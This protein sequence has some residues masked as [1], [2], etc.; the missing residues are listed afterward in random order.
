MQALYSRNFDPAALARWPP[1]APHPQEPPA[2]AE[3]FLEVA[4]VAW[5]Q[6]PTT[7]RKAI[8]AASRSGRLLH[9]S[10]LTHLQLDIKPSQ[11]PPEDS[12]TDDDGEDDEDEV[13]HRPTPAELQACVSGVVARG[14]RL[15]ALTL[16]VP[17]YN[18]ENLKPSKREAKV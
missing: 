9:D 3:A 13:E 2:P 1:V 11:D 15:Q 12:E 16:L 7:A 6:L 14:A 17:W 5:Q 10:M 4:S 18:Q 8:R